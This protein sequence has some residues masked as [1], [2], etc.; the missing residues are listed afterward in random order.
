MPFN[1]L[2]VPPIVFQSLES[3]KVGGLGTH[4]PVSFGDAHYT[5]I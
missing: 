1:P 4:A 2:S 5:R 3:A